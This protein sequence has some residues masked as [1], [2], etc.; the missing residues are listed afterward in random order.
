[1]SSK[2][3]TLIVLVSISFALPAHSAEE[4]PEKDSLDFLDN[5]DYPE[6]QVVP[7]ASERLDVEAQY[8]REGGSWWNQWTFILPGI[9]T[10]TAATLTG[11]ALGAGIAPY[12]QS[13]VQFG[14]LVGVATLGIGIYYAVAQPYVAGFDRVK[15][16]RGPGKRAMLMR[17]RLAEEAL[18]K[19]AAQIGSLE[20]VSVFSN[21][22][23]NGILA[24]YQTST[25][26]SLT[27]MLIAALPLIFPNPYVTNWDRQKE[28]KHKIYTPLPTSS[29]STDPYTGE[30]KHY[31]G[32]F[33]TW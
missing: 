2:L 24:S 7:R 9:A 27:A 31:A 8:E 28:Y 15:K 19:P 17:E 32:L 1:M 16:S 20:A 21:F 12:Q 6:L 5:I 10:L 29:I 22:I 23:A 14:Q 3:L 30:T 11:S 4:K 18:E 25:Q 26:Y 13:A 33:W